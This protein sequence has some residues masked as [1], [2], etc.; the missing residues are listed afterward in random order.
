MPPRTCP[1]P[2]IGPLGRVAVK[3]K[4]QQVRLKGDRSYFSSG[5]ILRR[6]AGWINGAVVIPAVG[7]SRP[8]IPI[9]DQQRQTQRWKLLRFTVTVGDNAMAQIASKNDVVVGNGFEFPAVFWLRWYP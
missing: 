2:S 4:K 9:I 1:T 6:R 5:W 7:R 8:P 3:R